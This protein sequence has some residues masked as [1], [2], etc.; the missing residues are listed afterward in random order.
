MSAGLLAAEEICGLRPFTLSDVGPD[1]LGWMNDP[2]VTRHL[3]S[4][5]QTWDLDSLA[6]W[7]RA[8]LADPNSHLLA[9]IHLAD[10]RHAGNLKIGPVRHPHRVAEV[11]IMVGRRELWGRG[12]GSRALRLAALYARRD[13]GLHKLT[14]G[15]YA[16][17]PASI[18]AF[19]KAGFIREGLARSEWLSGDAYVDGVRLGLLLEET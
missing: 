19:E 6:A 10:G 7:V 17:N 9:I 5:F 18:R 8:T 12:I 1:Y 11:G 14:A 2:L 13:L 16:D 15:C 4:R 3:E